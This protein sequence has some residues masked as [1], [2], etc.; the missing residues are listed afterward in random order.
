MFH[1]IFCV[2]KILNTNLH[3]VNEDKFLFTFKTDL[4]L[5]LC[6]CNRGEQ[7]YFY[8]IST[9]IYITL[10]FSYAWCRIKVNIH[11]LLFILTCI[12]PCLN[13]S[14]T[15]TRFVK[16][17]QGSK[18]LSIPSFAMD[19]KPRLCSLILT[20]KKGVGVLGRG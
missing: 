16:W 15:H 6:K 4:L 3:L 10:L 12:H 20:N 8:H 2:K 19:C 13:M 11:I 1:Q 7:M 9:H 14:M 18:A 5:D 17:C